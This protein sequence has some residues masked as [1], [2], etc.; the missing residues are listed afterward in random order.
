MLPDWSIRQQTQT[1]NGRN[2]IPTFS[3]FSGG[4][5]V[6]AFNPLSRQFGFSSRPRP[7]EIQREM[8]R[9][10]IR[11]FD[12]YSRRKVPNPAVAWVVEARLSQNL[13]DRFQV[14]AEGVEQT[15]ALAGGVPYN[16]VD[17]LEQRRNMFT[18]FVEA[19]IRREVEE[20]E[21]LWNQFRRDDPRA[22]AGFIRNLYVLEEAKLSRGY[23][24][25]IYDD[26]VRAFSELQ[27]GQQFDSA[28]D[29]IVDSDT[30]EDELARREKIMTWAEIISSDLQQLG[31]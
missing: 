21:H 11:E 7:T 13:N 14:W 2:D 28:R 31:R 20:T 17:N 5:P 26:A 4:Q 22:A 16:E 27:F 10:N 25:D 9:L 23:A 6:G 30:I 3:P 12:L 19:E 15:G 29:F 24:G 8:A 1:L 18:G